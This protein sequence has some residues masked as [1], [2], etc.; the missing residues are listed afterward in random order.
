L[1]ATNN[2]FAGVNTKY[3]I[4]NFKKLSKRK[5]RPSLVATVERNARSLPSPYSLVLALSALLEE[6]SFDFRHILGG[7]KTEVHTT[8][9][10]AWHLGNGVDSLVH[11][12]LEESL[13]QSPVIGAT[14]KIWLTLSEGTVVFLTLDVHADHRLSCERHFRHPNLLSVEVLFACS[15]HA[16]LA[17]VSKKYYLSS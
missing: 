11:L 1:A 12:E 2:E 8:A 17:T 4:R 10:C 7:E 3:M 13:H 5:G 16:Q 14:R 9:R 15:G 6:P